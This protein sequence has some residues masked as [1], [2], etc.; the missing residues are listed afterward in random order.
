MR[1]QIQEGVTSARKNVYSN[2]LQK[3]QQITEEAQK[4]KETI[5]MNRS[6][7]INAVKERAQ[8]LKKMEEQEKEIIQRKL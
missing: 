1:K 2:N 8:S 3:Y 7:D 5:D 6:I 4:N